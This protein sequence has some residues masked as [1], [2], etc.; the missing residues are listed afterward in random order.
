M[1]QG[2]DI[3]GAIE[4][5]P[6]CTNC[7][8]LSEYL[9]FLAQH[10]VRLQVAGLCDGCLTRGHP[11]HE[12]GEEGVTLESGPLTFDNGPVDTQQA[13]GEDAR[14]E[15]MGIDQPSVDGHRFGLG[16]V[17]INLLDGIEG[18]GLLD[19]FLFVTLDRLLVQGISHRCLLP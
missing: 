8:E 16:L 1:F 10:R 14:H 13:A 4:F 2:G 17:A 19:Q 15:Q 11:D 9:K 3:R 18:R 12:G 5:S 6:V 7:L